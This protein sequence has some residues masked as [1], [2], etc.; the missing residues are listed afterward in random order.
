[1]KPYQIKLNGKPETTVYE[2]LSSNG[3]RSR[4]F[5]TI[6]VGCFYKSVNYFLKTTNLESL[7]FFHTAQRTPLD[8]ADLGMILKANK[9]LVNLSFVSVSMVGTSKEVDPAELIYL[10]NLKIHGT[11]TKKCPILE[12]FSTTSLKSFS[13]T[14]PTNR[15]DENYSA[16]W[17]L[18]RH[19]AS[20]EDLKIIGAAAHFFSVEVINT[21]PFKLK[22]LKVKQTDFTENHIQIIFFIKLHRNTLQK[23]SLDSTLNEEVLGFVLRMTKIQTLKIRVDE[24]PLSTASWFWNGIEPLLGLQELKVYG[25]F[26]EINVARRLLSLV[27]SLKRFNPIK[28]KTNS[29]PRQDWFLYFLIDTTLILPQLERLSVP[30]YYNNYR[31]WYNRISFPNL[32]QLK[33]DGLVN[34]T[35][36][37]INDQRATL[38]RITINN[39]GNILSIAAEKYLFENLI[40]GCLRLKYLE[41]GPDFHLRRYDFSEL[42]EKTEPWVL[43]IGNEKFCFPDDH[44]IFKKCVK[45]LIKF[46]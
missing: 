10:T 35:D 8:K 37:L 22:R 34:Q 39:G 25:R 3:L 20:L 11:D 21:F 38:E 29:L 5:R 18:L 30:F 32:K 14:S 44:E 1:M 43:M 4:K 12:T 2:M 16:V 13:Y 36:L 42:M 26:P 7:E 46:K 24:L 6:K 15:K 17:E 23:L 41:F 28:L 40:Q 31:N 45:L 27:P 9:Q 19:L 33:L